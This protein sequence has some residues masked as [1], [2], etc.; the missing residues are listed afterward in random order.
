MENLKTINEIKKDMVG[1]YKKLNYLYSKANT[2]SKRNRLL[3]SISII[4]VICSEEYFNFNNLKG[5]WINDIKLQKD[6]DNMFNIFCK[7]ADNNMLLIKNL[8]NK[9]INDFISV[10]YTFYKKYSTCNYLPLDRILLLVKEFYLSFEDEH[11]EAFIK[12]FNRDNI[13]VEH[14]KTSYAGLLFAFDLIKKNIILINSKY[15]ENLYFAS[16]LAHEL[17][18][19]YESNLYYKSDLFDIGS[20]IFLETVSSF[21]EYAFLKYL[22]NNYIHKKEIDSELNVFYVELL[23]DAFSSSIISS[24]SNR[25]INQNGE[26]YLNNREVMNVAESQ[27]EELNYFQNL[28]S[29]QDEILYRDPIVYYIGKLLAISLYDKYKANPKEFMKNFRTALVNYPRTGSIDSFEVVGIT[30]EELLSGKVLRK[31][32][33]NFI[34]DN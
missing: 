22:K 6:I 5:D 28:P 11:L 26:I 25:I 29:Y 10:Q 13:Y 27:K 19:A 4:D 30:K 12:S 8:S 24:M 34:K 15:Q 23:E 14:F 9:T 16:S 20:T 2:K 1:F 18:H 3:N 31:E 32:L 17:G 7:N 33:K 21:F